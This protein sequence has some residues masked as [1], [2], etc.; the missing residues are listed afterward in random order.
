MGH[1]LPGSRANYFDLHDVDEIEQKYMTCN[2]SREVKTSEDAV[3][4]TNLRNELDSLKEDFQIVKDLAFRIGDH[5]DISQRIE[6]RKRFLN[7]ARKLG[8]VTNLKELRSKKS[9]QKRS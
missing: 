1:R 2:F 6:D 3:S 7:E 8:L 5:R 9:S 4:I